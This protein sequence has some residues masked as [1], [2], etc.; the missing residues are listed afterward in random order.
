MSIVAVSIRSES[1]DDYLSLFTDIK[2]PEDFVDRVAMNMGGELVYVCFHK[3]CSDDDSRV[4]SRALQERI[5]QLQ[6][7]EDGFF[8]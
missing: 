2:S 7:L 4:Y 5:E 8:D 1:G 3:V 6:Q